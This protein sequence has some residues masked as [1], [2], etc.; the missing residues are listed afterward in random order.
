[1]NRLLDY[2]NRAKLARRQAL[3]ERLRFV[4]SSNV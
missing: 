4:M 2:L 1:M 3:R